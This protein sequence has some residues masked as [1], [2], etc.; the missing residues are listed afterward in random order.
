M[1]ELLLSARVSPLVPPHL[2]GGFNFDKL[3]IGGLYGKHRQ[4]HFVGAGIGGGFHFILSKR[5]SLECSVSVDALHCRYDKY[6]EGDLP[7]HEGK[8]ESNA[9]VPLGTGVSLAIMLWH[10]LY[11]KQKIRNKKY[12]DIQYETSK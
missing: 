12:L 6:R 10:L 5:A 8:F 1:E 3:H 2:H 9:I 11:I 4:G 7:Y